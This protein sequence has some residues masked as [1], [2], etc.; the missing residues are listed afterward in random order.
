MKMKVVEEGEYYKIV[1]EEFETKYILD[2]ELSEEEKLLFRKLRRCLGRQK[3]IPEMREAFDY[4]LKECFNT[5]GAPYNEKVAKY[6]KNEI[7]GL[8]KLE[9]LLE[10]DD[11]EEIMV[12]GDNKPVYV[13]HRKYGMLKTNLVFQRNDILNIINKIASFAGR[14]INKENPLLDARLPNGDRVNATLSPP[15]LEGPTITIR[16]FRRE[17]FSIVDL[18]KFGTLTSDLAAFLWL[19]VEG[20]RIKPANIIIAGG[21]GSGKTTTLN[22][23]AVFI[24]QNERVITIEDTA[25]LQLP[26]EHVVRFEAI[27]EE[28][29]PLDFNRL[30]INSLRM[31][32]DRII[33][34]E[35]RGEEALTLFT[36]M[37]T[38]HEGCMGTL[39]ANNSRETISRLTNAPMNVPITMLRVLDLIIIQNKIML[40]GKIVRR[41][42]E[43]SE[44]AG[45]EGN[46]LLLNKLYQYDI[47]NDKVRSTGTPSRLFQIIAKATGRDLKEINLELEKRKL[48]LEFLVKRNIRKLTDV[49]S[50][51]QR[52]YQ[53]GDKLLLDIEKEM[54][55]VGG[56]HRVGG[57]GDIRDL[58]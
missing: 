47:K 51:I 39:H 33:V 26:L 14:T 54:K 11:L 19:A 57:I 6:I 28:G 9:Y 24:P 42:E 53:Y 50:W 5:I 1:E 48:I 46:N 58:L 32:P 10:N 30:L 3:I 41:I 49:V 55:V 12:N 40:N 7:F 56:E 4:I 20:F 37:N 15:A 35:I 21:T 8:G 2:I 18:I 31:R 44:V 34:G 45:I 52:Y 25:E 27:S 29:K 17:A 22:C 38:G 13:V 36:A 43:V 16:K 23:L